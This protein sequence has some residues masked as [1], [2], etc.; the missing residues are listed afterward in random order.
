[1]ADGQARS[2]EE[3]GSHPIDGLTTRAEPVSPAALVKHVADVFFR[4]PELDALALAEDGRPVGL[5]TRARLMLQLARNFGHPLVA[6]KRVAEIADLAPLVLRGDTDVVDAVS[7]ALARP[8]E[9]VY[10]EVIVVDEDG[11]YRGLLPVRRLVQ[12]QGVA[13]A[14]SR[15]AREQALSRAAELEELDAAR[16]RFLAHATHE[17]RS[18]L[19]VITAAADLVRRSAE[20]GAWADVQARVAPLLRAA[21]NLRGTVDNILDLARLEAGK[22]DVTVSA[23][24]VLPLLEDLAAAAVLLVGARDVEV[25]IDGGRAPRAIRSDP[26]KLRQILM[27]LLSNAAKFTRR[28]RIVLGAEQ[29]SDGVRFFVADTGIGIREEELPRL[30]IPFERVRAEGVRQSGAGLGLAIS[31]SLAELLGGR[32]AVTSRPGE[33]TRFDLHLPGAAAA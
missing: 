6:R 19:A 32:I 5:V 12:Q 31:R 22:A 18:P 23:V 2:L 17:L 13:L 27:N 15:R 28:G 9:A 20:R 8:D 29:A 30:F 24:E 11:R 1:M 3:R 25:E 21:T 10:D 33:G 16:T 14:H 7:R 4:R 26:E